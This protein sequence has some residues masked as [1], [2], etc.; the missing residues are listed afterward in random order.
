MS[1][2]SN[3]L[4]CFIRKIKKILI[5]KDIIRD[6]PCFQKEQGSF[7]LN[8]LSHEETGDKIPLLEASLCHIGLVP[9]QE[10]SHKASI[11]MLCMAKKNPRRRGDFS[12]RSFTR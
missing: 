11:T 1:R 8:V 6:A 7:I 5:L 4:F 2:K 12:K 3:N 10:A 9:W